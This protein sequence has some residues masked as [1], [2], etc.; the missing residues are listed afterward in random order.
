MSFGLSPHFLKF[1]VE[2]ERK[3]KN[4]FQLVSLKT[5]KILFLFCALA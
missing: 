3:K 4:G 5:N 2:K 1:S